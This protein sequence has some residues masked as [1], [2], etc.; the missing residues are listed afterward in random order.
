MIS[1]GSHVKRPSS[2]SMKLA[3]HVTEDKDTYNYVGNQVKTLG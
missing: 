2:L 1:Q 3:T